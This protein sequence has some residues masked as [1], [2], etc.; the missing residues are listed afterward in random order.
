M[1]KVNPDAATPAEAAAGGITKMRYLRFRE[2][3][4]T[5]ATL[6]FRVDAVQLAEGL[7]GAVPDSNELKSIDSVGAVNA[8]I[9]QYIQY[10]QPLAAEF[11]LRLRELREALEGDDVFMSHSFVRTPPQPQP[12]PQPEPQL[13]AAA[14]ALTPAPNPYPLSL[15]P[16][17][18]A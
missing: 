13:L 15:T 17:P 6:G 5:S 16:N 3:A 14:P 1:L 9:R 2:G 4:S 18:S 10:R 8:A 11:A 7:E 12:E